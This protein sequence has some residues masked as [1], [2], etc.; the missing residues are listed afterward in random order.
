MYII[1]IFQRGIILLLD[2]LIFIII[3]KIE[4]NLYIK[5]MYKYKFENNGYNPKLF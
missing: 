4:F 3:F 1:N 5:I 2:E